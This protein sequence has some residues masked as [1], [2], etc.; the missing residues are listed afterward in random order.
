MFYS[1]NV[2]WTVGDLQ[3]EG[4]GFTDGTVFVEGG[5]ARETIDLCDGVCIPVCVISRLR[6]V[7]MLI[8]LMEARHS[9]AMRNAGDG[10]TITGGP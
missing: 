2:I 6:R 5:L 10:E 1:I 7:I 8:R 9:I 4:V 3:S